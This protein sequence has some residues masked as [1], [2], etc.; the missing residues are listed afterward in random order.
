MKICALYKSEAK[1]GKGK[2]LERLI[3]ALKEL[4]CEVTNNPNEPVDVALHLGKIHYK[5]NARKNVLRLGPA[6]VNS[7]QDYKK[8][9]DVKWDS[10]KKADGIVYQSIFSKHVCHRFIGTPA[11]PEKIINNGANIDYY[12][13][14]NPYPTK[15]KINFLASTRKWI[16]QK[17]LPYIVKAFRLANIPDCA[18]WIAGDTLGY[19]KKVKGV[20]YLG[21]CED[22]IVGSLLKMATAM[23]HVTYLDAAP[24]SVVEALCAGCPVICT[25]QGGTHEYAKAFVIEDKRYRMKP[26]DLESPPKLDVKKLIWW[27]TK[28][29]TETYRPEP[30]EEYNIKNIALKYLNFFKEI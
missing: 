18:L 16:P 30:C 20:K 29:A 15:Y 27:M 1:T 6:H 22:D 17:R 8:L 9:N 11:C 12:K 25:N 14:L 7:S 24:N 28:F 26:I 13:T 19:N 4:G 5:S 23:I 10:V 21:H 3:V 2:F